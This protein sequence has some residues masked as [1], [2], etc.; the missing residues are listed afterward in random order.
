VHIIDLKF[1]LL[2]SR[3]LFNWLGFIAN[4]YGVNQICDREARQQ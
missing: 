2:Q 3:L 4:Y 1:S